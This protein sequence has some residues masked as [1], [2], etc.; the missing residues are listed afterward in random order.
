MSKKSKKSPAPESS[1]ELAPPLSTLFKD[2]ERPYRKL[3]KL[4]PEFLVA[5]LK[6]FFG[7][8][9]PLKAAFEGL[10]AEEK[11]IFLNTIDE[12]SPLEVFEFLKAKIP[13]AWLEAQ[14]QERADRAPKTDPTLKK[15]AWSK[16]REAI[17]NEV[18]KA[19]LEAEVGKETSQ[20]SS[21]PKNPLSAKKGR[22]Y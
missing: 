8:S 4:E 2:W 7:E 6:P 10:P 21:E 11:A 17:M 15:E 19:D 13:E 14:R 1:T 20:P 22:R 16:R 18:G 9:N 12:K 3:V 5:E